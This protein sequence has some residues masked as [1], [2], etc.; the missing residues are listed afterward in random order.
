MRWTVFVGISFLFFVSVVFQGCSTASVRVLPGANGQHRVVVRDVE[1]H[2]AEEAAV[3]GAK[4]YCE[5]SRQQYF[6][7]SENTKYT[8]EMDE[9]ARNTIRKAS[10]VLGV[11][12]GTHEIGAA[13]REITSDKDYVS[14]VV[15]ECR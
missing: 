15:F 1:K 8:G 2:N 10:G 12:G 7:V 3:E 11:I 9:T 4:E 13:G 6:V 14:E 5:K